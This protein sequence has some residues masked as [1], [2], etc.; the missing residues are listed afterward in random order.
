MLETSLQFRFRFS[1]AGTFFGQ[2]GAQNSKIV[3]ASGGR[4]PP[5]PLFLSVRF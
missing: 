5:E 3:S 1:G 4:S 2:G